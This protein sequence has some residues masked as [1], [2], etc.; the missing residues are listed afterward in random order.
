MLF[1]RSRVHLRSVFAEV[2]FCVR[3]HG[4]WSIE[5][6]LRVASPCNSGLV[7]TG[8]VVKRCVPRR[9]ETYSGIDI[10]AKRQTCISI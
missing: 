6:A 4:A 1:I 10:S 2:A 8:C 5:D 3:T 9:L 7:H